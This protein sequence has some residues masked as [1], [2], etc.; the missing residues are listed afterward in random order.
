M[1]NSKQLQAPRSCSHPSL[2]AASVLGPGCA[3][4]EGLGWFF[5]HTNAPS[6]VFQGGS[7]VFLQ[8]DGRHA[9]KTSS[10]HPQNILF[11]QPARLR[12]TPNPPAGPSS[13]TPSP[14]APTLGS[15]A[16]SFPRDMGV[17]SGL[18]MSHS[19]EIPVLDVDVVMP[20]G[21][22]SPG[23][24]HHL[25]RGTASLHNS[26]S[27]RGESI[28]F[29]PSP[30]CRAGLITTW[31][32]GKLQLARWPRDS[33][34]KIRPCPTSPLRMPRC[35]SRLE[36]ASPGCQGQS[37]AM[38]LCGQAG[39]GV[40]VSPGGSGGGRAAADTNQPNPSTHGPWK[41]LPGR[42][43][44]AA[45]AGPCAGLTAELVW[46]WPARLQPLLPKHPPHPPCPLLR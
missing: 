44:L 23:T 41:E 9:W 22:P 31:P 28:A 1:L 32:K 19:M 24:R 17:P 35:K 33:P 16:L 40:G 6:S 37:S 42:A 26:C 7:W 34:W 11:L 20:L 21:C 30:D 12:L 15:I 18:G 36:A 45:P 27:T 4:E 39:D 8:Q 43:S 14:A 13:S 5:L 46:P 29:F 3:S 38:A 10:E 2:W 25:C